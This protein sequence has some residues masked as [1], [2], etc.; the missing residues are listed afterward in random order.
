MSSRS[1]PKRASPKKGRGGKSTGKSSEKQRSSTDSKDAAVSSATQRADPKFLEAVTQRWLQC[2]GRFHISSDVALQTWATL[3]NLYLEPRRHYHTLRHIKE[4]LDHMDAAMQSGSV[5]IEQ[6]HAI[7]L[8]IFFHDAVY[9][10]EAKDNEERSADMFHEF[11]RQSAGCIPDSIKNLVSD[12]ILQTK[13]HLVC[14][15]GAHKDIQLFLDMDLAIL[16]ANKERYMQYMQEIRRE[17]QH[18]PHD[19]YGKARSHV[20]QGFLGVEHLYRT[21]YFRET[22]ELRAREN[23]RYEIAVLQTPEMS[24]S[25]LTISDMKDLLTFLEVHHRP[26]VRVTGPS[27]EGRGGD[28]LRM[29]EM[30]VTHAVVMNMDFCLA[31]RDT[32]TK[33]LICVVLCTATS[34]ARYRMEARQT[35]EL[36]GQELLL[37]TIVT[38]RERRG[39]GIATALIAHVL[40]VMREKG[41]KTIRT[42]C[43]K[44][45]RQEAFLRKQ[46]FAEVAI[47]TEVVAPE[48]AA[49]PFAASVLLVEQEDDDGDTLSATGSGG[50]GGEESNCVTEGAEVVSVGRQRRQSHAGAAVV[51][52]TEAEAGDMELCAFSPAMSF[53]G[54]PRA[55]RGG[56][57]S[58][59]NAGASSTTTGSP[60]MRTSMLG[61]VS[62][63]GISSTVAPLSP[64]H[65]Y[66]TILEMKLEL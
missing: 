8:L 38:H 52:P 53:V 33:A 43:Y 64:T 24:S 20:L 16:G 12:G 41:L 40:S 44:D 2:T 18:V 61:D 65:N 39:R 3:A 4:L 1:S 56:H 27:A 10:P 15:S 30:E 37:H 26:A 63:F 29:T 58:F 50:G 47:V 32:S 14:P 34:E 19:V 23:L 25:R 5:V 11:C 35:H 6:P 13:N 46:G 59:R 9:N 45:S 55:V 49:S 62:N 57:R 51:L 48:M 66:D 7:L 28:P 17:Y 54:S 36:M 22:L 21:A 31:F 60:R 42:L